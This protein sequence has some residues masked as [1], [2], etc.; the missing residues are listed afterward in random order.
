MHLA[1]ACLVKERK[2][3]GLDEQ[4]NCIDVGEV[5]KQCDLLLHKAHLC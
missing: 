3:D 1:K 5:N 4:S 2:G